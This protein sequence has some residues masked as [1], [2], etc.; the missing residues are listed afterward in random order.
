[1]RLM[2][3]HDSK[4]LFYKYGI[5]ATKEKV[6]KDKQDAI[7]AARAIGY[8]VVLKIVSSDI[9]HKSDVG[10]VAVGITDDSKL[11]EAYDAMIDSVKEKAPHAIIDGVMVAEEVSGHEIIVGA[12]KDPQFGPVIMVGLGGILVEILKDVSFRV[13]PVSRDD[14]YQMLHELKSFKI[15]EGARG[16]PKADLRSIVDAIVSISRLL[17]ENK[18]I[19]ELDINPLMVSGKKAVAADARIV[20]NS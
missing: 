12:K 11:M 15:L 4:R 16:K 9:S 1:M 18:D 6:A 2:N 10:G 13:V 8:P 3:E 20:V 17:S 14:A 5:K 7:S 19:E